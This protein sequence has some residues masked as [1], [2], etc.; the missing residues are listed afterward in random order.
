M[1]PMDARFLTA[2]CCSHQVRGTHKPRPTGIGGAGAF[3]AAGI[4]L[5]QIEVFDVAI[6]E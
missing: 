2:Y 1:M 3:V 6:D 4:P 5:T